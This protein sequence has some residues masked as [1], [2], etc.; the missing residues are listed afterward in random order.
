VGAAPNVP[1]TPPRAAPHPGF[2]TSSYPPPPD[3]AV[4]AEASVSALELG[5]SFRP[6]SSLQPAARRALCATLRERAGDLCCV[7]GV[8]ADP[9]VAEDGARVAA[10][11]AL[12]LTSTDESAPR[13][14]LVDAAFQKPVLRFVLGLL[15]VQGPDFAVQ[16]EQNRRKEGPHEWSV[17][18]C[19]PHL[20]VLSSPASDPGLILTRIFETCI[21]ELRAFYDVIV[22]VGPTTD[23][24]G[25]SHALDA[26][27]DLMLVVLQRG[28]TP[29]TSFKR[30]M[31]SVVVT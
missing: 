6:H 18:K 20:H 29:P 2:P 12:R 28:Q 23:D 26:V 3:P 31:L 15:A 27:A 30:E 11:I 14:L 25:A 10:E 1:A 13:V 5:S 4:L 9:S 19:S 7:A 24:V 16:L 8:T 22:I 17:L 21:V